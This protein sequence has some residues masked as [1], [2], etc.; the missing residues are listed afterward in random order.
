MTNLYTSASG[1]SLL[2]PQTWSGGPGILTA[3]AEPKTDPGLLAHLA[4]VSAP[5]ADALAAHAAVSDRVEDTRSE[6]L[7]ALTDHAAALGAW[8][9]AAEATTSG[10]VKVKAPDADALGARLLGLWARIHAAVAEARHT[11]A[12]V[13]RAAGVACLDPAT[14]EA[15]HVEAVRT[16]T[17]ARGR[18]A[19]AEASVEAA[20]DAFRS[21]SS[22]DGVALRAAGYAEALVPQMLGDRLTRRPHDFS[23]QMVRTERLA[24]RLPLPADLDTLAGSA[25]EHYRAADKAAAAHKAATAPRVEWTG[26]A[27]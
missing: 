26:A 17:E 6:A 19:E 7:D 3:T 2:V 8:R 15:L 5:V 23:A 16:S 11:A 24:D 10:P 1:H 25:V 12:D 13:D 14:R 20:R 4:A 21:L 9:A 18:I 22:L 27:S